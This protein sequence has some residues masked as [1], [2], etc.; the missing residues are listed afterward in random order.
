[1]YKVSLESH[2]RAIDDTLALGGI[3]MG[4]IKDTLERNIVNLN[5]LNDYVGLDLSNARP[6]HACIYALNQ[7]GKKNLFKLISLSHT[8]HFKK[9]ATIPKTVL[10]QY[11]EGLIV[12]SGCEKGEFFETV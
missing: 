11:R 7:E 3:L 10:Q 5:Q 6:F 1:K 9:V 12:I 2:H 4:L 8:E